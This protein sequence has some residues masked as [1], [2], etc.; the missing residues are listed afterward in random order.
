M[1]S[2]KHPLIFRRV[3]GCACVFC[4]RTA[5]GV[6]SDQ[7]F[8]VTGVSEVPV[9]APDRLFAELL[10]VA[11]FA[12][13]ILLTDEVLRSH[14]SLTAVTV[15]DQYPKSKGIGA[16]AIAQ[17][18]RQ[19]IGGCCGLGGGVERGISAECAEI[20]P[21]MVL[22]LSVLDTH[23]PPSRVNPRYRSVHAWTA[24]ICE[25]SVNDR[26]E[27][28]DE[29]VPPG[30]LP[31]E[32]VIH[33]ARDPPLLIVNGS[34]GYMTT[35]DYVVA[36]I[37]LVSHL[38]PDCYNHDEHWR[39]KVM[40]VTEWCCIVSV[41]LPA[42]DGE[43]TQWGIYL[44]NAQFDENAW[45][46]RRVSVREYRRADD[47]TTLGIYDAT[48]E[49]VVIEINYSVLNTFTEDLDGR[50]LLRWLVFFHELV[51]VLYPYHLHG[52]V[53]RRC[54]DR[55][56]STCL[57]PRTIDSLTAPSG[58]GRQAHEHRSSACL[59][60]SGFKSVPVPASAAD[61]DLA[62]PR[63]VRVDG[64][65]RDTWSEF[66]PQRMCSKAAGVLARAYGVYLGRHYVMSKA[67]HRSAKGLHGNLQL[68]TSEGQL[69]YLAVLFPS[70]VTRL[71]GAGVQ[72]LRDYVGSQPD[73]VN[74]VPH[75]PGPSFR[76]ACV[77]IP[78][79]MDTRIADTAMGNL[80]PHIRVYCELKG[81]ATSTATHKR[82][83]LESTHEICWSSDCDHKYLDLMTAARSPTLTAPVWIAIEVIT[84]EKGTIR[85]L[86]KRESA[87]KSIS[88]LAMV[89]F[90]GGNGTYVDHGMTVNDFRDY[91]DT[92]YVP[93]PNNPGTRYLCGNGSKVRPDWAMG[94]EYKTYGNVME[95]RVMRHVFGLFSARNVTLQH[96]NSVSLMGKDGSNVC[97]SSVVVDL[98]ICHAPHMLYNGTER[99]GTLCG[100][101]EDDLRGQFIDGWTRT[102]QCPTEFS[103]SAMVA[104]AALHLDHL[105]NRFLVDARAWVVHRCLSW[106]AFDGVCDVC[107][108]KDYDDVPLGAVPQAGVAAQVL[109]FYEMS[110]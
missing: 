21:A 91:V 74:L 10:T 29:D 17:E 31:A 27:C 61:G 62:E 3:S 18:D 9:N 5:T 50:Q 88:H 102:A 87:N 40:E 77:T 6:F 96:T 20:P 68:S 24:V 11:G 48:G 33:D 94:K 104:T 99:T 42:M 98:L 86:P 38:G 75:K 71:S 34:A 106:G 12:T 8:L 52:P 67:T 1:T 100:E 28:D 84:Y 85:G 7:P 47:A 44:G 16:S 65:S 32:V 60:N 43:I 103:N 39:G 49:V 70:L 19:A 46:G 108:C 41:G 13:D 110:Y 51:H 109:W 78:W 23:A 14:S 72:E 90:R 26:Y 45:T 101:S 76:A 30:W 35:Q 58:C 56:C 81:G 66:D 97:F 64:D 59:P 93:H 82:L 54:F 25:Y 37:H 79:T 89:Q 36:L 95:I 22:A 92:R 105:Y 53:F 4:R 73:N 69:R 55:L 57:Q 83:E 80:F 107:G 63:A 15:G 2:L